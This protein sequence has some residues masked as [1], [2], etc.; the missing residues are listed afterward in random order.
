MKNEVYEVCWWPV[1][2]GPHSDEGHN[3]I[4]R[5]QRSAE[6]ALSEELAALKE[7]DPERQYTGTVCTR[8]LF[9][10]I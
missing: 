5:D 6:L 2:K 10:T 4:F 7:Y 1:G 9:P 3:L 8:C